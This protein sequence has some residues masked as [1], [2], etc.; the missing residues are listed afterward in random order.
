MSLQSAHI[1]K[2]HGF[3]LLKKDPFFS[4]SRTCEV[5][6]KVPF[7]RVFRT[8]MRILYQGKWGGRSYRHLGDRIICI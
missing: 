2:N 7:F 1:F 5:L 8:L 3:L 4:I 6:P